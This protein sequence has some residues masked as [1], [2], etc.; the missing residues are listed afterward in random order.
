MKERIP[1]ALALSSEAD[2]LVPSLRSA[3]DAFV[4]M[5]V[6]SEANRREAAGESIVHMEVGQPG[7]PAPRLV[8]EAAKRAIDQGPLG[9]TD[10]LGLPALRERIAAYYSAVWNV[11]VSPS[12]IVVTAGSSAGFVLAFLALLNPGDGIALPQPGYPCYRQIARVL[13]LKSILLPARAGNGFMIAPEDL[14]QVLRDGSARAVLLASPSNPTGAV[15]SAANLRALADVAGESGAWFISDEIYHGLTYAEPATTGLAVAE[16]A[17]VINSFSKYF[18]MTGWRIGWMAVPERLVRVFERLA[19]N[20]YISPPT[21]SQYA[22]LAAFDATEELEGYKSV[23]AKNRSMLLEGLPKIG[24]DT[25][26]P[27]DGAFYIYA[28]VS[29]F[30]GDSVDFARRMLQETGV[31]ATPG[32]DFDEAEGRHFIR[33]SYA[34]T[35]ENMREAVRRLSSWRK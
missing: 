33:F 23:Y 2:A 19:Q 35:F 13:G 20:L 8:R 1:S 11:P 16:D 12:R 34:G 27:A 10:A 18:S 24:F 25:L 3:I 4:V 22:A 26:A 29:R 21:I 31:A 32:V 5:D 9:Y 30:T 15:L 17:I 7:T 6:M 28:D 14:R